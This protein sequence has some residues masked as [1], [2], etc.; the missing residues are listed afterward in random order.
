[1]LEVVWFCSTH[2]GHPLGGDKAGGLHHSE[3]SFREEVDER[4]LG[5]CGYYLFLILQS[6]SRSHLHY[7]YPLGEE[8]GEISL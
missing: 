5:C 8:R 6:I 4:D 7:L 2:L 1:M 3:P